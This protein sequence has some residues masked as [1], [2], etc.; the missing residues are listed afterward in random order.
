MADGTALG[1]RYG[2]GRLAGYRQW[3]GSD[4][5]EEH[6]GPFFFRELT[7]YRYQCAFEAKAHHV[8]GQG[9]IH[10]GCMMSF[11]DFALFVFAR[12]A[13]EDISGVTVSFS[14]DFIGAGFEGDL[15][16]AD[17]EIVRET[18]SLVF[19]RGL[20]TADREG[21]D[22]PAPLLN[23]SGIIKKIRPRQP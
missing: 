10:G 15:V 3:E 8:N 12:P 13:L 22:S 18:G 5:Y 6:T 9:A 21:A 11:A 7:Q 14:S 23:F 19:L 1:N 4:P 17:G 20:M 16:L 2:I